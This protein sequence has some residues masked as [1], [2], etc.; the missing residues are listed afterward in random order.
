MDVLSCAPLAGCPERSSGEI[1]PN[2]TGVGIAPH[3][4]LAFESETGASVPARPSEA[5]V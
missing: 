3:E 2:V 4:Y 5:R 1:A